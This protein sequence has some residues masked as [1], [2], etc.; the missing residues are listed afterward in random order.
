LQ[1]SAGL[2]LQ[3]VQFAAQESMWQVPLWHDSCAKYWQHL[4]PQV[5]QLLASVWRLTHT[6]LH[7]FVP[8][9]QWQVP[10]THVAL[11]GH[12]APQLPQLLASVCV[13]TQAPLQTSGVAL[14]HTQLLLVHVAPVG[15]AF[16]Q[17][18]QLLGSLVKSTHEPLQF[19]LPAGQFD[20]HWPLEHTWPDGQA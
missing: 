15:Q 9:G 14:G 16:P 18:P 2:P 3:L 7:R 11:V 4:V 5:P 13:L 6:P 1:P 8:V 17:R 20:V 10:P 12:G 19:V